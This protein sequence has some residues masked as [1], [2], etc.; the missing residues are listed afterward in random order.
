MQGDFVFEQKIND[1]IR[2]ELVHI[3]ANNIDVFRDSINKQFELSNLLY[4]Y[5]MSYSSWHENFEDKF[6]CLNQILKIVYPNNPLHEDYKNKIQ[7]YYLDKIKSYEDFHDFQ[8]IYMDSMGTISLLKKLLDPKHNLLEKCDHFYLG[9]IFDN[10]NNVLMCMSVSADEKF[11]NQSHMYIFRSILTQIRNIINNIETI[12]NISVILHSLCTY[13]IYKTFPNGTGYIT[14]FSEPLPHMKYI[15]SKYVEL[16]KNGESKS[17]C[18]F[19][20]RPIYIADEKFMLLWTK[21][22]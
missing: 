13:A 1:K 6:N 8:Q 18:G 16:I 12:S 9:M 10:T 17:I 2:F 14:V 20:F 7:N 4:R 3:T 5:I 19:R 22:N 11:E 15:L 21:L